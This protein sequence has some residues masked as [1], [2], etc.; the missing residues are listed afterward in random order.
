MDLK[1]K[2]AAAR[3]K[4]TDIHLA[5][6]KIE[7]R[8]AVIAKRTAQDLQD[9]DGVIILVDNI[10]VKK[11]GRTSFDELEEL[12]EDIKNK[13]QIQPVVVKQVNA[14]SYELISGE[15]RYRAIKDVLKQ[16]SI[17]ATI[18]RVEDSDIE[19]RFVQLS[20][21]T[22]RKDYR[23][24]DLAQELADI[25][26]V[27]DLS[28]KEIGQQIGKS[29]GFVSKFVGLANASDEVKQA[30]GNGF[31]SA[32]VWFNDKKGV[33]QQLATPQLSD[34]TDEVPD[35]KNPE[36]KQPPVVSTRVAT[37]SIQMDC[38]KDIALILQKVAVDNN[39]ALIDADLSGNVTKKQ[40]QAIIN[41]RAKDIL[42][43]L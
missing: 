2:I 17:R 22:Q 16:E 28:M 43:V 4:A 5:E 29:E 25:K 35:L 33:E 7:D 9:P 39:L 42:D 24:L 37:V 12:A 13:G 14:F 41:T 3:N 36:K 15:R 30:I 27:S 32:S 20:E 31:L 38:A 11:Q 18:R 10:T 34:I 40:L 23:P 6:S 26:A 21:N 19:K 1:A 8:G